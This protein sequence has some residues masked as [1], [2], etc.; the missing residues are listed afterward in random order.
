LNLRTETETDDPMSE[1]LP[2][3]EIHLRKRGRACRW[4]L[5][6]TEAHAVMQ[7]SAGSWAAAKYQANRALFLMLLA[8]AYQPPLLSHRV[9][10]RPHRSRSSAS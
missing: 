5:C 7:G 10:I 1:Q 9:R 4:C 8:S 3:F 6:T 2:L